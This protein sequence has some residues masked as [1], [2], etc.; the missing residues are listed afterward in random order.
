MYAEN[1][2]SL[3]FSFFSIKGVP[4]LFGPDERDK[5]SAS[6]SLASAVLSSASHHQQNASNV[7][8]GVGLAKSVTQAGS[9]FKPTSNFRNLS[10]ANA[11]IK[12]RKAKKAEIALKDKGIKI[13]V[14]V[15]ISD[16]N[17][18]MKRVR[19]LPLFHVTSS[20][21]AIRPARYVFQL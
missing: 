3:P 2:K 8:F 12:E 7:R 10:K 13:T 5:D 9:S 20:L 1:Q 18:K 16:D 15:W 11:V 21:F 17:D 6:G 14:Q 4:Q 19:L